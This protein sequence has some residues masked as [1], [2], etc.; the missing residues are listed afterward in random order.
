M[1]WWTRKPAYAAIWIAGDEKF[2]EPYRTGVMH[3]NGEIQKAKDPTRDN[4][5]QQRR[6]DGLND[7]AKMA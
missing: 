7:L 2:F 1:P 5:A 4:P 6:L 3:F